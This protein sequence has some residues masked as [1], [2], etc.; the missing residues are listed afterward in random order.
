M[1][2]SARYTIGLDYGSLSCRGVLVRV[3]DGFVAAEADLPYPH[4][5]MDRVLPDGTPLTGQFFLQ[6]PGDYELALVSIVPKLLAQ[7]GANPAQI[8]GIGVDFTASTVIP[9]DAAYRPLCENPRFAGR[10]HAW[11]KLWK[12]HSAAPQAEALTRIC[13]E[14]R[15]PY[16]SWYGGRIS[17][18]C[19]MAKVAQVFMEDREVYEAADAFV[20]A[21]DYITSLLAGKPVFGASLAA[22][23]ALWH[24]ERGYPDEAFF[25]AL[26]PAFARMPQEKLASH[27]GAEPAAPG[28]RVG[29]LCAPMASRLGLCTGIC[30][31]A[32]QMDA[33]TPMLGLGIARPAAMLMVIGTSTGMMLLGDKQRPVEG[34]TACLPET[35]YPGLWGYASGQA[36]VGDGFQWFAGNCL[37]GEYGEAAR[38]LG[39]SPQQYLSR[40]AQPLKPGQTGLMALD[41]FNGNKSC[42][43]NSRLS[44][45]ILGLTLQTRPEHI[46]R[47]LLEATAFGARAVLEAY[48]GAQVPVDEIFACGG[49]PGKNPLLMQIYADVLRM[50]LKVSRCRQAPALG[51]AIYAAGAA[52]KEAGFKDVFEAV[53]AMHCRDFITYTPNAQHEAGYEALYREYMTLHDYFGRG[54]NR[55]MER[56]RR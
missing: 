52:G 28:S 45:M 18:E 8:V 10:P 37:P 46:Y 22:A 27:F 54:G 21:G 1:I 38:R 36:S 53:R 44:G 16:L 26:N 25:S 29:G 31:S 7:S 9:V 43:G 56:L 12:H 11:C 49:I 17:P 40:L 6:H 50:P 39:L 30:V 2:D 15:R 35:Y 4:G 34:I 19:L 14:Q 41:W 24:K 47:A 48:R 51:A 13:R 23:K 33:Y 32:P 42:L 3:P 5:I 55:V 20:E